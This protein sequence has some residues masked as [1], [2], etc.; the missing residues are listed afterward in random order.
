LYKY[1]SG[2]LKYHMSAS[3]HPVASCDLAYSHDHLLS[4]R[5]RGREP[6]GHR[7]E[8]KS[9]F[10][11]SEL[12][13]LFPTLAAYSSRSLIP[14]QAHTILHRRALALATA[15]ALGTFRIFDIG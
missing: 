9:I 15:L 3:Y 1:S 5:R 14:T 4:V 12:A 2:L 11:D 6:R 7:T 10:P 8:K 13:F